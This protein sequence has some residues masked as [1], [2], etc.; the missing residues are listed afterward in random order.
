MARSQNTQQVSHVTGLE[1]GNTLLRVE[2]EVARTKLAEVEHPE[3]T[4]TS[5]NEGLKRDLEGAHS[6]RSCKGKRVG[7][8]S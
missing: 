3:R 6:A 7:A 1:E 2:L 5:K 8:A 4:L